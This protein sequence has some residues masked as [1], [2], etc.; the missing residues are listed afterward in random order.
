MKKTIRL[1]ES[2]LHN[3]I[4][5]TVKAV[6]RE[7]W[8]DDDRLDP[9]STSYDPSDVEYDRKYGS[10]LYSEIRFVQGGDDDYNEIEQMFCGDQEGYCEGNSQPVIDYLK[11][12]DGEDNEITDEEP[13]IANNDTAYADENGE[14]ILLY[15]SSVGG[16]FLL[17][18]KGNEQ[19]ID[20]Y[21]NKK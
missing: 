21:Q 3:L 9:E 1:S 16:C 2:E 19:E 18:R 4:S 15:N 17:Y 5:E 12:W 7:G 13:S 14:Y 10:Q 8:Y 20:W 6:I 11:Q